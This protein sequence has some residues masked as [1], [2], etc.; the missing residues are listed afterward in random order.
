[1][2]YK[3]TGPVLNQTNKSEAQYSFFDLLKKPIEI[4]LFTDPLCPDAWSLDPIIKKLQLEYGRFFTLR[5]ILSGKWSNIENDAL[6]TPLKLK[7]QWEK[8]AQLTGMCCD[9]D[10][11]LE[12]PITYPINVSI[13]IKTA[14][15]QGI[16]AGRRYLRK[17]QEN[18][19]L[20]RIDISTDEHLIRL[21]KEAELDS[22]EFERDL[23]SDTAK[24]ALRCDLNLTK[25]MEIDETPSLVFF[26]EDAEDEGLKLSGAYSY[27]IYVK[28]L[29]QL[30]QKDVQPM[31]KPSLEEFIYYFKFISSLEVS[32][33][34][35]WPIEKACNEMKK[36]KLKRVVESVPVKHGTFW[37]YIE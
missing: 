35:D 3:K 20:N 19:F 8:T 30:L 12:D 15:L 18:L 17:V 10:L 14:E 26:N 22:E 13:A 21:A 9:G 36:L 24:R 23:H 25:E 28:V 11:W 29:K 16:K 37:R 1:M 4:Y 34:F 2:S 32:V 6:R 7:K 33:V 31:P 27:D 5:P